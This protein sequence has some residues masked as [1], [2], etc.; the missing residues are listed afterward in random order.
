MTVFRR[1]SPVFLTLMFVLT[2]CNDLHGQKVRGNGRSKHVGP[3]Y[4]ATGKN[5]DRRSGHFEH[6]GKSDPG[7]GGESLRQPTHWNQWFHHPTELDS[8]TLVERRKLEHRKRIADHLR[9][10]GKQNDNNHLFDVADQLEKKAQQ[11]YEKR[12]AAI[13]GGQPV[14]ETVVPLPSEGG[15]LTSHLSHA[16]RTLV[17]N[18]VE[19]RSVADWTQQSLG[20][21]TAYQR[22]LQNAERQLEQRMNIA[23]HL[24]NLA[25]SQGDSR[26]LQSSEQL[27]TMSLQRYTQQLMNITEFQSRFGSPSNDELIGSRP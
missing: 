11:H 17:H 16:D 4:H 1:V 14:E 7:H 24:R 18:D 6:S 21:E 27:E 19:N 5:S 26:L 13:N 8:R 9:Q 3:W 15:E 12:L 10:V 22:R 20:R 25:E 2:L 23:S